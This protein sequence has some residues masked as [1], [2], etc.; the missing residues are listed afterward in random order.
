VVLGDGVDAASFVR[1]GVGARA[2]GLGGAFVA[3]A[4]GHSIGF[5]NPAALADC[6]GITVGG[7]YT[8]RFGQGISF[9]S[10]SASMDIAEGLGAE[11]GL[12]RSSIDDIPYY[13]DEG[14]GVFSEVQNLIQACLGYELLDGEL[15][16]SASRVTLSVGGGA[17]AYTH[18][19][20]EG[21]A[22]GLGF[23][24]SALARFSFPW[25]DVAVAWS[26]QDVLGTT[27]QWS[28]TDHDPENDVPWINRL[29]AAGWFL[30]RRALLTAE[31]DIALGRPHLNKLRF[32][33]EFA[34]VPAMAGRVGASFAP[35]GTLQVAAG[36][37]LKWRQFSLDYAYAP[38]SS[39]GGS[40]IFSFEVEF[41][42]PWAEEAVE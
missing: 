14:E 26:S 11:L 19:L 8:N 4:E 27:I 15:V 23:D 38:H 39:L 22:F 20:L 30:E 28:G 9:Q 40:H 1:H 21:S 31:A 29:G 17:K 41:E 42:K 16:Q 33:L 10:L 2:F 5:W 37:S 12:V 3:V 32:G 13:G 18:R 7:M 25:G 35:D 36:G 34:P 24:L 6:A